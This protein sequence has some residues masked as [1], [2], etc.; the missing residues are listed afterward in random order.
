MTHFWST[1][2]TGYRGSGLFQLISELAERG[3]NIRSLTEP[4]VDTTTPMGKAFY[5]I[6]AVFAQ[7]RID[8]IRE[9]TMAGLRTPVPR[10]ALADA[11][12]S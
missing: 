7:L 12:R 10:A 3:I 6:V 9:N 8:T 4:K 2:S 11:P 5:R 1:A